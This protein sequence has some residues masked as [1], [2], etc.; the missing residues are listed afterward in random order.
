MG[1][2]LPHTNRA[3]HSRSVWL[4][5][6]RV[7]RYKKRRALE[8]RLFLI[9]HLLTLLNAFCGFYAM[10]LV[11]MQQFDFA[12]GMILAGACLDALDGRI[13]R[14]V[15]TDGP[16]GLQ[17]DSLGDA[18]SFC[19][20][21]IF[22]CYFWQLHK[23]GIAGVFISGLFL[24]AGLLRLAR[25]NILTEKAFTYF[26]GVPTTIAGGFLICLFLNRTSIE[27]LPC[28]VLFL[29][30][31]V[32]LLAFLMVSSIKFPA[33]K[34]MPTKKRI[35][36]FIMI[37]GSAYAIFGVPLSKVLLVLFLLYFMGTFVL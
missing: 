22:L 37:V 10:I 33:F 35:F 36:Y 15:G 29:A 9:P 28:F 31:V 6:R 14:Y 19:M 13:A 34:L 32:L 24:F 1:L 4:E 23:L 25:F 27:H 20:A 5:S 7:A 12:A 3:Q 26:L 11:A 2:L 17:L 21:P 30:A 16:F 18:I 8:E